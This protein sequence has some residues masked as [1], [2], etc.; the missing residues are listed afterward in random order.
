MLGRRAVAADSPQGTKARCD[1]KWMKHGDEYDVTMPFMR[2]ISDVTSAPLCSVR[3]VGMPVGYS[4]Q[5]A[6]R[7]QH[8]DMTSES[9]KS[10]AR[11]LNDCW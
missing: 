10:R 7:R 2:T 3:N 4:G 8:R 5:T 1:V 9:R 6:L 11:T